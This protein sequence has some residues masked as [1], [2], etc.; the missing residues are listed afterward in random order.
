MALFTDGSISSLADLRTYEHT[1]VD[2]AHI[3][4]IDIGEKLALAQREIGLAVTG[5]LLRR[6]S[7]IGPHRRLENVVVTEPM[8]HAHVL[9]TIALVYRDAYGTQ[10]NDR[11]AAKW[12]EFRG[13][14]EQALRTMF[15]IGI[16]LVSA[17]ISKAPA[18]IVGSAH[19]GTL[20]ERSYFVSVCF[21]GWAGQYGSKSDVCGFD[22]ATGELLTVKL[23]RAAG[24]IRGYHVFTGGAPDQLWRQTPVAL[25][26]NEAFVEPASGLREDL[27]MLE[28]QTPDYYVM[29][30]RSLLRG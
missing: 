9:H 13:L 2:A 4:G 18:P 1:I 5:F 21:E 7:E 29:N 15:D 23:R 6:H 19:G 10:L 22:V 24:G 30:R 3:E 28:A 17:P 26:G 8:S 27:P 12:K 20:G 11:Y 16:G 14:A 25:A